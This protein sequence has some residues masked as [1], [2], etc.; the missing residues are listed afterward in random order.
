[1]ELIVANFDSFSM[2][3]GFDVSIATT[4]STTADARMLLSAYGIPFKKGPRHMPKRPVGGMSA[5]KKY[6]ARNR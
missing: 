4:A 2:I 6:R 3:P 1:M 5:L